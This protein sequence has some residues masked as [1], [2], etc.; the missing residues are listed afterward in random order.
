MG[1]QRGGRLGL[2][3]VP[4]R[5]LLL[6]HLLYFPESL[7]TR[8]QCPADSSP[9]TKNHVQFL[10]RYM[11]LMQQGPGLRL[12]LGPWC[13]TTVM[14]SAL[15]ELTVSQRVVPTSGQGTTESHLSIFLPS[16]WSPVTSQLL[17][18]LI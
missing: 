13:S 17:A 15:E 5:R 10:I 7:H 16:L 3:G 1:L 6:L 8:K 11:S 4:P 18:G 2:Q 14:A 12:G 9:L